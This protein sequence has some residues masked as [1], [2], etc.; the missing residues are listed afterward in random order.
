[1]KLINRTI[2][3]MFSLFTIVVSA[4]NKH[5]EAEYYH[6]VAINY[7]I[8]NDLED[9]L[10]N[11]NT[12]IT[13]NERKSTSYYIRG[14]IYEKK[15][16]YY[17]AIENFKKAI[18]IDPSETDY[19]VKTA[20]SYKYLNDLRNAC[21][22]LN[23]ACKLGDKEACDIVSINCLDYL[24]LNEDNEYTIKNDKYFSVRDM[25]VQPHTN[26]SQNDYYVQQ[27]NQNQQQPTYTKGGFTETMSK[28]E[29]FLN[30]Y[31]TDKT[32]RDTHIKQDDGTWKPKYKSYDPHRNNDAIPGWICK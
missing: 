4:Q 22:F 24:T 23:E 26:P 31:A 29:V 19:Y 16:L 18:E 10:S 17:S 12:S 21:I 6:N 11:I 1:M 27:Y 28:T 2:L 8:D 9:A 15:E 20:I 14:I 3:F 25:P 13:Y 32:I 7:L 30:E 5:E